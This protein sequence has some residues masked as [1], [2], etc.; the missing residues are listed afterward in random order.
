MFV[1]KAITSNQ[2]LNLQSNWTACFVD[3]LALVANVKSS[4]NAKCAGRAATRR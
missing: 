1:S 4:M 3:R 2:T